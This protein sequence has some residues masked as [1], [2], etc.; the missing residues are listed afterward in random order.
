MDDDIFLSLKYSQ[1]QFQLSRYRLDWEKGWENKAGKLQEGSAFSRNS[2]AVKRALYALYVFPTSQLCTFY[3][4]LVF[5]V[6]VSPWLFCVSHLV[7]VSFLY[8]YINICI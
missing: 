3:P 6:L 4:F 2:A 7:C 1:S 8:V 5:P